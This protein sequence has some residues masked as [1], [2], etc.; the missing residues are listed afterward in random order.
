MIHWDKLRAFHSSG[1]EDTAAASQ[2]QQ[3]GR[4]QLTRSQR[5]RC[6]QAT[7]ELQGGGQTR[8][9]QGDQQ[10]WGSSIGSGGKWV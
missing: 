8:V 1:E 7:S 6:Q 9:L 3:C 5:R 10:E 2:N 4:P